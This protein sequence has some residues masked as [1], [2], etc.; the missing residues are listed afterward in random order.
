MSGSKTALVML[1]HKNERDLNTLNSPI[2]L[3][4]LREWES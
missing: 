2:K 3:S 1:L 4:A